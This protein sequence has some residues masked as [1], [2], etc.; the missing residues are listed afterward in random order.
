MSWLKLNSVVEEYSIPVYKKSHPVMALATVKKKNNKGKYEGIVREI[1]KRKGDVGVSGFVDR[2]KLFIVESSNGL[3]WRRVK[4]L[5]IKEI[6]AVVKKLSRSSLDFI[7]LEDPDIWIEKGVVHI[8]FSIA[9]KRVKRRGY[10]VAL[11]HA[12]GKNLYDLKATPPVL[13]P[14]L[15]DHN[16]HS[17]FKEVAISP[18]EIK[19]QKINLC[20]SGY[21]DFKRKVGIS[22][23]V[24]LKAKSLSENWKLIKTVADPGKLKY[25]WCSGHLS[26][27][28]ILPEKL[29]SHKKFLIAIIN[30]RSPSK[31]VAEKT[32]YGDF[33]TGFALFNPKTG[34][35]PW[36]S[37]ES[38]VADPEEK[39]ITFSSD[40]LPLNKNEILLYAH[41]DDSFIRA[42]KINLKE[43]K[44]LLP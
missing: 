29:I 23:I 4:E 28:F 18:V 24:S 16:K 19:G 6:D 21:H 11:G 2:S 36:I 17:G 44:K 14:K 43:L 8:Y 7:G 12:E 41:T 25:H 13:S 20:E 27:A 15:K 37:P 30:G 26:P 38:L 33:E 22:T 1:I 35:L 39:T 5:K 32:F 42:Y 40:Y 3:S 34:E 31:K 9:F 10:F